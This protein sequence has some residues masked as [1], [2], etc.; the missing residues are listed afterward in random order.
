MNRDSLAV[1]AG[2]DSGARKSSTG[3]GKGIV[4]LELTCDVQNA[5]SKGKWIGAR[6]AADRARAG[7]RRVKDR[8]VPGDADRHVVTIARLS[9][10]TPV[11]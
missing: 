6:Q 8:G 10:R 11:A 1:A 3:Q 2:H 7:G 9:M 4:D 5:T